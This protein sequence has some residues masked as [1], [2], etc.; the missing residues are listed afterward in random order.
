DQKLQRRRDE[1]QNAD[2]RELEPPRREREAQQRQHGQRP[3]E[4]QRRR[5]PQ[6]FRLE[7]ARVAPD[8]PEE[9]AGRDRQQDQRFD[10]QPRHAA[11]DDSASDDSVD[12]ERDR[13]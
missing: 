7:Y 8:Q 12:R 6:R 4:G 13:E 2:G 9:I 11:D 10:E 5:K 3:G 1:L